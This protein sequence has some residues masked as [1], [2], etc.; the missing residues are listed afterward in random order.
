M[1][2]LFHIYIKTPNIGYIQRK[3]T[4]FLENIVIQYDRY[5]IFNDYIIN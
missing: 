1:M 3:L 5:M 2:F 4:K